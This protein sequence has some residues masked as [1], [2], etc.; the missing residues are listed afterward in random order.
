MAAMA[1]SSEAACCLV[2]AKTRYTG[3]GQLAKLMMTGD[4]RRTSFAFVL[5][6]SMRYCCAAQALLLCFYAKH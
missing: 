2:G 1:P 5:G 6:R 3:T 4:D